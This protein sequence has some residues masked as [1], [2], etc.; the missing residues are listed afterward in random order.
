MLWHWL[1]ERPAASRGWHDEPYWPFRIRVPPR[2]L[3]SLGLPRQA[4]PKPTPTANALTLQS[5]A[6]PASASSMMIAG[7]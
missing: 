6:H 7:A 5:P 4:A 2:H 1:R 3:P